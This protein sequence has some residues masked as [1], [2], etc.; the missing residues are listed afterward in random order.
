MS[1]AVAILLRDSS[2]RILL[3]RSQ[4]GEDWDLPWIW[5]DSN[6]PLAVAQ[7]ELCREHHL[8]LALEVHG[9]GQLQSTLAGLSA[10]I[11]LIRLSTTTETHPGPAHHW[12]AISRL[13]EFALGP[14]VSRL[15]QDKQL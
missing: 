9:S 5:T 15:L 12:L 7:R 8:V 13:A 11:T 14:L 1:P 2:S 3:V 6:Q 10:Q 4:S